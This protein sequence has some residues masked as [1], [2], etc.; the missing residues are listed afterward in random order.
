MLLIADSG[1]TK[2]D[3]VLVNPKG[4]EHPFHT[5]GFNPFFHS[6]DFIAQEIRK[7]RDLMDHAAQVTEVYFYGAGCSSPERNEVLID[8]LREVFPVAAVTVDHDLTGAAY[9]TCGTEPGIACILGTGSNSCY[10]DGVQIHEKVP[11][12]GYVLGDEAGGTWYGKELLRLFLYKELPEHIHRGLV[13]EFK[14][15]K[16]SIFE[17]V[18]NIPNPNVYLASFMRF[19][20]SRSQDAWVRDFMYNGFSKFINIHIWKYENHLDVPVHFVG[21]VAYH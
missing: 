1:S 15:N 17:H 10:F 5:M 7:N 3:W 13:E 9:A 6:T 14:L 2:C 19:L 16:E 4:E 20:S 11:A 21:S 12:L 18:Y 8:A